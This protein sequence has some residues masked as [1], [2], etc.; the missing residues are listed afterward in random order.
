MFVP[1][2]LHS[3]LVVADMFDLPLK[4]HAFDLITC[5]NVLFLISA[6]ELAMV[7]MSEGLASGGKLALLNP[8]EHLDPQSAETFAIARQLDGLAR[9]TLINW[10]KRA[11]QNHRWTEAET[12]QLFLHAGLTYG[13]SVLKVGPGFARFSWGTWSI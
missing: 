3:S 4:R 8:S 13:G 6:P 5:S 9:A 12:E 1:A 10:A 2:P 11:T 7:E